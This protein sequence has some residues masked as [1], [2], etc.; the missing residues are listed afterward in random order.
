MGIL[1]GYITKNNYMVT[2]DIKYWLKMGLKMVIYS[3]VINKD[4]MKIAK[5]QSL[6]QFK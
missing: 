4:L 1:D 2:L 6:T 3:S 5:V